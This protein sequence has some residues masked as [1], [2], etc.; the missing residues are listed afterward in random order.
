MKTVGQGCHSTACL[1]RRVHMGRALRQSLCALMCSLPRPTLENGVGA[2]I[3]HR[4]DCW[5]PKRPEKQVFPGTQRDEASHA[6]KGRGT[7]RG[8]AGE[9]TG[10]EA[11][12]HDGT[13]TYHVQKEQLSWPSS[14]KFLETYKGRASCRVGNTGQ[15]RPGLTTSGAG[16]RW[17][18]LTWGLSVEDL[19][20]SGPGQD[21]WVI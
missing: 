3:W 13:G 8:Q 14:R 10:R 19:G 17:R 18:P 2:E 20:P 12:L 11:G 21:C 6:L 7:C 15:C 16:G 9:G 5:S 4:N 1:P